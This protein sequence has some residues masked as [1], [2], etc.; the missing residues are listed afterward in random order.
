MQKVWTKVYNMQHPG[1]QALFLYLCVLEV[2]MLMDLAKPEC[3]GTSTNTP[4]VQLHFRALLH[5]I[6]NVIF[7]HIRLLLALW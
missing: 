2:K 1:N 7:W 6:A 5:C 3:I 4:V